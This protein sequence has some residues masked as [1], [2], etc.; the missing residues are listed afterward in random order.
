[1]AAIRDSIAQQLV[2]TINALSG[3][4]AVLRDAETS[5]NVPK[6]AVVN[7]LGES[8]RPADQLFYSCALRLGVAV[9][10]QSEDAD[11]TLDG[12][13]PSRY[14]DRCIA[15]VERA[16][17]SVTWSNDEIATIAGWDAE[18]PNAENVLQALVNVSVDYRHNFDDPDT[19]NPVY[20]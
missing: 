11:A 6:L 16:V 14:L 17:H 3:W 19:Y 9:Y 1:M 7:I 12:S 10:A 13:N 15:D 8:K 20:T 4:S 2:A 18:P 5:L